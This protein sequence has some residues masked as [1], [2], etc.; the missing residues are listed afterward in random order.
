M[1]TLPCLVIVGVRDPWSERVCPDESMED[2]E[3]R[4]P[5]EDEEIPRGF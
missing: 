4:V 5:G 2:E 3:P 1:C